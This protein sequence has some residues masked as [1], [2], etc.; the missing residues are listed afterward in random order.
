MVRSCRKPG[1][2]CVRCCVNEE[3]DKM[4]VYVK[5][6]LLYNPG[7][8]IPTTTFQCVCLFVSILEP[9][10]ANFKILFLGWALFWAGFFC[11]RGGHKVV[12]VCMPRTKCLRLFVGQS[13]EGRATK[14]LNDVIAAVE[15]DQ[16]HAEAC[17]L[18]HEWKRV[19]VFDLS[20]AWSINNRNGIS[21]F[22]GY[23]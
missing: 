14:R 13:R 22:I 10:Q 15:I 8:H 7:T 11:L 4:L 3:R 19:A 2:H 1:P 9:F 12:L 6:C 20:K 17:I 5:L 23:F 21:A 18:K 16:K